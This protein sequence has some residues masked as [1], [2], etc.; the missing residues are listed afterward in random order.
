MSEDRVEAV[1][2]ALTVLEAFRDLNRRDGVTVV[3]VT[4]S[5]KAAAY[6]DRVV[7]LLDGRVVRDV[8]V[9]PATSE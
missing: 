3:Q 4:H 7:E 5:D 1:E 6:G 8:A 9:E 2:R